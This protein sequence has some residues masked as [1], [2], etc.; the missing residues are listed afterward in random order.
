MVTYGGLSGLNTYY[1]DEAAMKAAGFNDYSRVPQGGLRARCRSTPT[2]QGWL[3]V[4]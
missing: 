1:Q 2:R 3:P 4:Y